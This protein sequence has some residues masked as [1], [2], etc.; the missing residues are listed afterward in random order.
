M[1]LASLHL[2]LLFNHCGFQLLRCLRVI[3]HISQPA[4]AFGAKFRML[5]CFPDP[6]VLVVRSRFATK[7]AAS[8]PAMQRTHMR[9]AA[10]QNMIAAASID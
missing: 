3:H 9:A 6:D 5:T 7:Y 2:L 10:V 1:L 4:H 8:R